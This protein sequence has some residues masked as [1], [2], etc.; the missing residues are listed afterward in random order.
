MHWRRYTAVSKSAEKG[1]GQ[2][3]TGEDLVRTNLCKGICRRSAI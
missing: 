3:E 2:V 1:V